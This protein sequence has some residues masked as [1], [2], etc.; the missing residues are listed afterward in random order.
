MSLLRWID[1][2]I[3]CHGLHVDLRSHALLYLSQEASL[4]VGYNVKVTVGL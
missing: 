1:C 4:L 3:V 2:M